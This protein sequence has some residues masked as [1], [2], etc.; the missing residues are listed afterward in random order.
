MIIY[1]QHEWDR[2]N[3]FKY[4]ITVKLFIIVL[5][6]F[7]FF[8]RSRPRP[9]V[10]CLRSCLFF[11]ECIYSFRQPICC[12]YVAIVLSMFV[13]NFLFFNCFVCHIILIRTKKYLAQLSSKLAR[14]TNKQKSNKAHKNFTNDGSLWWKIISIKHS[15][16]WENKRRRLNRFTI[17]RLS[18]SGM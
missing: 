9:L 15:L 10:P 7:I 18:K 14:V 6:S 16:N 11:V 8:Y 1:A 3:E 13:W 5:C 2:F 12:C 4:S 17:T